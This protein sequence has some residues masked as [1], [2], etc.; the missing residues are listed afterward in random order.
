MPI[1][2]RRQH[3]LTL[4]LSSSALILLEALL[5]GFAASTALAISSSCS[6]LKRSKGMHS[7]PT[8]HQDSRTVRHQAHSSI[9]AVR[10][11]HSILGVMF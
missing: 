8:C 1:G 11:M 6:K 5:L 7:S 9:L 2:K 4:F 3:A 10:Y